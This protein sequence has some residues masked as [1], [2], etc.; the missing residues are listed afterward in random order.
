[1]FAIQFVSQE[2]FPLKRSDA[3]ENAILFMEDWQVKELPVVEAGKVV[4]IITYKQAID[5]TGKRVDEFMQLPDNFLV[6]AN[7]H[8]WEVWS[9]IQSLGLTTLCLQQED[10]MFAG[11]IH[12]KDLAI[13]SY[14]HS[15]LMQEGAILV[16]EVEA[17]QYSLAEMARI[18]EANQAKIIHLMIEPIK[19]E[20]NLLQISIKLNTSY[21]TYVIASLERFAYK[22]VFSSGFADPNHSFDYRYK[23]LVKYLNT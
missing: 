6:N 1:M 5:N 22:V 9:K 20:V 21:P 14:A 23:W 15:A 3:A 2:L 18:C 8:I 19:N 16:L 17:I 11:Q 12:I 7:L 10:G 13:Q 4:G